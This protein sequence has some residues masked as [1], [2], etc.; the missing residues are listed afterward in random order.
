MNAKEKDTLKIIT[1]E[2]SRF[3]NAK[4]NSINGGYGEVTLELLTFA[5]YEVG[6]NPFTEFIGV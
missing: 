1:S 2:V 3:K 4:N 6:D 5:R